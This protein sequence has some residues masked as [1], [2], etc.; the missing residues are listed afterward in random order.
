VSNPEERQAAV[1]RLKV[2]LKTIHSEI[3]KWA[4]NSNKPA[5]LEERLSNIIRLTDKYFVVIMSH[6]QSDPHSAEALEYWARFKRTW[7]YGHG[8]WTKCKEITPLIITSV[9]AYRIQ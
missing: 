5:H 7:N 9:Q 4:G 8:S 1:E 6:N 3:Q 2:D